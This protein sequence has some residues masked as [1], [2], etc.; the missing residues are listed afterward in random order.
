MKTKDT[1]KSV[2]VLGVMIVMMTL[3][4]GRATSAL[5]PFDE[6]ELF[7][8]EN[9]TDGDLG[10]HFKADGEGWDRLILFN[11]RFR[12]LLNVAS[13]EIWETKSVSP[14]YSVKA[15]SRRSMS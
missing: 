8:E 5:I 3:G 7:F 11:S 2:I 13:A 14:N 9:A 10:L 6:A 15:L 12:R 1:Q 4:A